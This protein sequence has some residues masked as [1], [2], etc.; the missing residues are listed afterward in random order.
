MT[1]L[2]EVRDRM[3]Q[4][5]GPIEN[6]G[7]INARLVLRTGITLNDVNQAVTPEELGQVIQA[8]ESMGYAL[9]RETRS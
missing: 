2:R 8:L 1:T 4:I 6:L 5:A 3:V 7:F 9:S